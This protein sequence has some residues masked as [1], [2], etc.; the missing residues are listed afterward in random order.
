MAK[1]VP[2]APLAKLKKEK[3]ICL[4]HRGVPYCVVKTGKQEVQAF[5][6]VCSHK[7]LAMFPP[8]VK[9]G[10]LICPFHDAALVL[11]SRIRTSSRI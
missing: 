3:F 1:L 11:F 5:V 10:N 2:V 6:T 4:E 9:K 8:D 7:D